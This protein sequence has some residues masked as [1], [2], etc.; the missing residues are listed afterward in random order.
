MQFSDYDP[1]KGE[2]LQVLTPDGEADPELLPDFDD[3]ALRDVFRRMLAA[4]LV[5]RRC[6]A[7]QREG[8]L[9][10][11]PP[12]EGQEA[13]QVG[14]ALALAAT[15]WIVPSFRELAA[16]LVREVPLETI[17][18]Y[19]MGNEEGSRIP[20]RYRVLPVSIPVGS[21]AL[22]AAGMAMAMQYRRE[23]GAVICY[24]GDGATSEGDFHEAMTFAAVARA[25]AV[26]FCQNNAWA[27]SVPRKIQCAAAIL[28]AKG[29]GYGMPG[30]QIDGNDPFAAFL[31]TRTALERARAGEGPSFIE[32]VTYRLGPHTTSD[33]P[34]RYREDAEVEKMRLLE[35]L[36]RYRRF[37]EMRGLWSQ[38]WEDGLTAELE[39]WM[40]EA[41]R[42]AETHPP[43]GP[44]DVFDYMFADLPPHLAR[45]RAD[46]QADLA[47]EE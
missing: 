14:S 8:R 18:L 7:L 9:G 35:P 12:L 4:R 42:Q 19:W 45:Q 3:E 30:I 20:R 6:V 37:L 22:H 39:E 1:L 23:T 34:S 17:L 28:A 11:Y 2:R 25:P 26:F 29:V 47:G 5:D 46:L 16:T 10:T 33:D 32:A 40:D 44:Q 27:I 43:P 13:C 31:A 36:L 21:H 24:F 41:V 38:E 15:D